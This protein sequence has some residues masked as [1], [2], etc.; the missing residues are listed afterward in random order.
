[1]V[2]VGHSMGGHVLLNLV[3]NHPTVCKEMILC[4]PA[5]FET[6]SHIERT[7]YSA[8]IHFLDMFSTEENSLRQILKASFMNYPS[9]MDGMVQE[10]VDLMNKQPMVQY[11]KMIEAC[12]MGMMEE[13]VFDQLKTIQQRVLVIFG[14]RDA[15]IPNNK[16]HFMSTRNLAERGVAQI[17][18]ARLEMLPRCGHFLQLEKPEQTNKLMQEFLEA[19]S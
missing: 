3:I 2:P 6:Y 8:S 19:T 18:H 7:I 11:R 13:P 4:A 10:L 15:L 1:V 17:P 5:G 14:E 9:K 16:L 12:I